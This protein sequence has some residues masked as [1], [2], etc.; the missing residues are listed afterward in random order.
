MTDTT[1]K[2]ADP[3]MPVTP[4]AAGDAPAPVAPVVEEKKEEMPAEADMGGDKTPPTT[5]APTM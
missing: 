1:M 2:P 4:P 5:P 3:M